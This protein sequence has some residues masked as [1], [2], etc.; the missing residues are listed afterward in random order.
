[1]W[2][3]RQGTPVPIFLIF[4]WIVAPVLGLLYSA[5]STESN[6][7]AQS[8]RSL[9][10]PGVNVSRNNQTY[11]GLV[12]LSLKSQCVFVCPPSLCHFRVLS[13]VSAALISKQ[14]VGRP[15]A[16]SPMDQRKARGPQVFQLWQFVSHRNTILFPS[17]L[18]I[19]MS[20]Y[21]TN[22]N[23]PHSH[24]VIACD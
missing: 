23:H 2:T 17:F 20:M 13:F 12:V 6:R 4:L 11:K 15:K 10:V 1:M 14:L 18:D 22:S 16:W 8:L 21:T 7:P 9:R 24:I 5:K 19:N 3:H